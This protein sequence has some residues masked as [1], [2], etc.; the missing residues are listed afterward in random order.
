M[1]GRQMDP[2]VDP[3]AGPPDLPGFSDV[4]EIGR[5]GFGTVY[6]AVELSLGRTVAVKVLSSSLDRTARERFAREGVAMSRLSNHPNVVAVHAVGLTG[7]ARPYL[8][9]PLVARGSAADLVSAAG[10]LPWPEAVRIVVRLCGALETAHRAGIVHRD[11]KPENVLLSD[12]G[13][14]LLTDFGIARMSG[15]FETTDERVTASVPY[16]A[17]EVLDG[18]PP[19]VA[20]DL[21][22]LGATLFALLT[23]HPCFAESGDES[24]VALY[25]RIAR[26]PVP[27]LRPSGVPDRV[28][29]ALERAMAKAPEQR[30][31]SAVAVG[32]LLQEAQR[33]A[34]VPVT[35]I[36]L[37]DTGPA[38]PAGRPARLPSGT[39]ATAAPIPSRMRRRWLPA[40]LTVGLAVSA[41]ALVV[42]LAGNAGPGTSA[43]GTPASGTPQSGAA[44]APATLTRARS[45][46]PLRIPA[47]AAAE[48]RI[49]GR[50]GERIA[51]GV[52][53]AARPPAAVA[54]AL[55]AGGSPLEEKTVTDLDAVIEPV[56]LPGDGT[57]VLRIG[58]APADLDASV[59]L[60]LAP[61]DVLV[62]TAVG[63]RP[64][65]VSL[66]QPQQRGIVTFTGSAGRR[67]RVSWTWSGP[68]PGY[69]SLSLAR[70]D[71]A[72]LAE[73][74]ALASG[75]SPVVTLPVDGRYRVTISVDAQTAGAGTVGVSTG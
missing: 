48:V 71:G 40:G 8:V 38:E 49:A 75:T 62:A 43:A 58:P 11:I 7:D 19:S 31:A 42:A 1:T 50:A 69:T 54:V 59:G 27:D 20:S 5:G 23:G 37:G 17:P 25:L 45:V 22:S 57:Y 15:A 32:T 3:C 63:A 29:A 47:G 67:V 18:R 44:T 64:V 9:M 66:P 56:T 39:T 13:E 46:M 30:P 14:P 65:A 4:V 6:R 68:T 53:L 21:Y 61:D 41:V 51:G 60:W 34:G 2:A 35:E 73:W 10:P 72:V 26:D 36:A 16:A 52:H 24:L 12:Y 28:C 55:L 70:P 74:S 33:D